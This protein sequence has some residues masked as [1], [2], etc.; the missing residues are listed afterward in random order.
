MTGYGFTTPVWEGGKWAVPAV[1]GMTATRRANGPE[2]RPRQ[3]EAPAQWDKI[4]GHVPPAPRHD[5]LR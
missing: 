4:G 5:H 1:A 2:G 3:H